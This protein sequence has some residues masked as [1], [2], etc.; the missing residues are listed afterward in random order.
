MSNTQETHSDSNTASESTMSDE[1]TARTNQSAEP[2]TEEVELSAQVDLLAAENRRLRQLVA[3]SQRSRYRDTAIALFGVGLFC[4]ALGYVTPAA[5]TVLFALGGTGVF[6]GVLT[7]FLTPERFISADVGQ[8]VYRATAESIERLCGDLGLSERRIYLATPATEDT[9][10][11][12]DTAWL[13]VPQSTETSVPDP[14]TIDSTFHLNE[15]Q[16][17]IS[18]RP[19]GNELFS[20]LRTSLT[21]PLGTT[22]QDLCGQ[23]SDAVVEDFELARGVEYDVDPTNGRVSIRITDPLYGSGNQFD[24]PIVSLFAVGLATGLETPI[25][26]TVT[27]TEP[28]AVTL[29]WEPADSDTNTD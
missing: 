2:T 22:A 28:L 11:R 29:R 23:L 18:V 13:F 3:D 17:G 27:G 10:P 21:G 24:H 1:T 25:E 9:T 20:A 14:E 15:D 7:Y 4:G 19:T 8:R 12:E 6:G 16:H 5:S 26:S